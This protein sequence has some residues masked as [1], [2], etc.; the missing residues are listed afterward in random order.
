MR[1][2]RTDTD[3]LIVPRTI[4]SGIPKSPTWARPF[5]CSA[6]GTP[7]Y[8]EHPFMPKLARR[9]CKRTAC[10]RPPD[11][12]PSLPHALRSSLSLTISWALCFIM[13]RLGGQ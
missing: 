10:L 3:A 13:L 9:T 12:V 8:V 11:A 2:P 1:E 4:V 5:A 7:L 6:S